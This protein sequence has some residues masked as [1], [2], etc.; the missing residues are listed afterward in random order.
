MLSDKIIIEGIMMKES[1]SAIVNLMNTGSTISSKNVLHL[2]GEGLSYTNMLTRAMHCKT[3]L[4][5]NHNDSVKSWLNKAKICRKSVKAF[6]FD[7][8]DF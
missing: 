7:H 8:C 1:A 6:I 2:L 5:E 4:T 3:T